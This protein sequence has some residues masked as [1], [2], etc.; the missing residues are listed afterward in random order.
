[1][2]FFIFLHIIIFYCSEIDEIYRKDEKV[3]FL[4]FFSIENKKK[5]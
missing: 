2:H 4:K 3:L 1:M 5:M